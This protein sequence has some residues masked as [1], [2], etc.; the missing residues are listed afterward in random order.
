MYVCMYEQETSA[1]MCC[2][3][4]INKKHVCLTNCRILL[5]LSH[6]CE[7]YIIYIYIYIH[8]YCIYILYIYYIYIIYI[9]IYIYYGKAKNVLKNSSF[10]MTKI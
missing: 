9:Y 1:C 10:T 6:V 4:K 2:V 3:V 7:S 5:I 8:V